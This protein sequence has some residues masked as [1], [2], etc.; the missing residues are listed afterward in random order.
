[1]NMDTDEG[2]RLAYPFMRPSRL[3]LS[4]WAADVE[5]IA[6]SRDALLYELLVSALMYDAIFIQD[7]S[8]VLSDKLAAWFGTQEGFDLLSTILNSRAFIVLT[9]QNWPGELEELRVNRPMLAR[10]RYIEKYATKGENPFHPTVAQLVFYE[11][12]DQYFSDNR[13][14]VQ[15]PA[16]A[17]GRFDLIP[18]FGSLM[19]EVLTNS[20]YI[21]WLSSTFGD[22]DAPVHETI[23]G[24]TLDPEEAVR[25]VFNKFRKKPNLAHS[26]DGRVLFTRSL[27]YQVAQTYPNPRQR[28]AA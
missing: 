28:K 27:A 17:D 3:V 9:L 23:A 2:P 12:L 8:I 18:T 4:D 13:T 14:L 19:R 1:M 26:P 11:R 22:V 15:H 5:A 24:C 6:S 25:R 21:A 7:E 16:A 20:R 10:A